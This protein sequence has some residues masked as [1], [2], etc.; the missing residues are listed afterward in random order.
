MKVHIDRFKSNK[1][2]NNLDSI[3]EKID[4]HKNDYRLDV[5]V[6]FPQHKY[7]EVNYGWTSTPDF[8]GTSFSF[9]PYIYDG[10]TLLNEIDV[11]EYEKF[12]EH[13]D[14][15]S[16]ELVIPEPF[17]DQDV[18]ITPL[19]HCYKLSLIKVAPYKEMEQLAVD[20]I[21]WEN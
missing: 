13:D 12:L 14:Y 19:K 5:Y 7:L 8:S 16:F 11:E 20:V 15:F 18:L 10:E 4:I 6:Y 3:I 17:K 1:P 2:E 9:C 21:E